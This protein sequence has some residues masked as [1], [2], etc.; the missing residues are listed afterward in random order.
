MKNFKMSVDK[1]KNN[2]YRLFIDGSS[3][4]DAAS[5][6]WML[7]DKKGK[8][9]EEGGKKIGLATNNVAEYTAV[10]IGLLESLKLKVKNLQVY[11]DSQLL[12]NQ[13]NGSYKVYSDNLIPFYIILKSIIPFF[14]KVEFI[15]V[16]REENESADKLAQSTRL[17]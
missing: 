17:F 4:P 3:S 13:I 10:I 11:S 12:I 15:W 7:Y 14:K 8:I 2:S 6:A 1:K 5:I 9:I 16:P